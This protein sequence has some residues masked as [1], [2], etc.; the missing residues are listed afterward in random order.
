[1]MVRQ[2]QRLETDKIEKE[3]ARTREV[4]RKLMRE[5]YE[6]AQRKIA[7]KQDVKVRDKVQLEEMDKM[8][9]SQE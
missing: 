7:S 3:R 9:K 1:M 2:K 8:L 6:L 5:N 4:A